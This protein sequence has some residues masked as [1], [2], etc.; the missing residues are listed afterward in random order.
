MPKIREASFGLFGS[1][2]KHA[3][4]ENQALGFCGSGG[5]P[6]QHAV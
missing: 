1:K 4:P 2:D 5:L 3:K 6:A